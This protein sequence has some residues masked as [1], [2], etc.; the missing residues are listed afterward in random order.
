M[1]L[2]TDFGSQ[3]YV[4]K[5]VVDYF[6]KSRMGRFVF[7]ESK[8]ELRGWSVVRYSHFHIPL[9]GTRS[10]NHTRVNRIKGSNVID[11]MMIIH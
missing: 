4:S 10:Y 2:A 1:W 7:G 8:I 11:Q 9:S 3:A 6:G 5:G